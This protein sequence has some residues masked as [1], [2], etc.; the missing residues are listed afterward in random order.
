MTKRSDILGMNARNHLYQSRYNRGRT[1]RIAGSK[2]LTKSCLRKAKLSVPKLYR[3]F[4]NEKAVE[5]FDFTR[6]PEQFVVK[7][8]QGLG[9]EGIWVIEGGGTYAGEWITV[10]KR[11]I[12][13]E[14][15]KLHIKDIL[16]GRFSTFDL[17]DRAFIEERVLIH[18][19]FEPICF[20]G[21]PD[22]GVLVFNR[23][24]VMA[25]LRLPTKE[26]HGKANMVQGAIACGV[27]MATGVTI[28]AI[29]HTH[30]VKFFPGTRRRLKGIKIPRWDEVLELAVRA[31]ETVGLGYC[32]VDIALQPRRTK[33]GK[34]KSIPMVLELN[35]QPGLKIQLANQDGLKRRLERV[36]GL[37]VKTVKQGIAIG[38]ALFAV[39]D[40][41]ESIQ[42]GIVNVGVFEDIQIEDFMGEK[43][44]VKAKIDT[45]AFRTSID[46]SLA[47]ELGLLDPENILWNVGYRSSFGREER[48]VVGLTF[49]LKGKK[50]KTSASVSDRSKLKR[51][52][53]VGRR[54]L[55]GFAVRVREEEAGQEA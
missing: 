49:Y 7:P 35:S 17:S 13:I 54:D 11:T 52:I 36:E 24:P 44:Q 22:I 9:G 51:E 31:T 20:Q 43:H 37:K 19:R 23:I 32:R 45:G 29:K 21:T 33:K 30:D 39:R 34:L 55:L 14:D 40:E 41:A 50:I 16:M 15:L 38:R 53:I 25:F 27:D 2:L 6:L 8:S 12:N 3:T 4:T 47:K 1:K 10:D 5:K 18:P 42:G 46:E 28:H 48:R 26:S